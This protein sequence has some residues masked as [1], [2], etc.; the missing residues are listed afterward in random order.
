MGRPAS[1]NPKN[2]YL[3]IRMTDEEIEMIRKTAEMQ[4]LSVSNYVRN[5]L[6]ASINEATKYDFYDK[7]RP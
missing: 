4:G 2:N 6:K 7:I 3:H 5:T 1:E